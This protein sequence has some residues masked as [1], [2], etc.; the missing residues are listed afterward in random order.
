MNK[1]SILFCMLS[2]MV[3]ASAGCGKSA[4]TEKSAAPKATDKPVELIFTGLPITEEE[5]Q[6]QFGQ[7]IH[8][9]YPHITAK[10]IQPS[11]GT[12][13]K[14]L[15][16][17]GTIPDVYMTATVNLPIF[18]GFKLGYDLNEYIKKNSFDLT[19]FEPNSLQVMKD[20]TAEQMIF[21]LPYQ[22][23]GYVLY[24]NKDVFDKFGVAYPKDGMTWDDTYELAKKL[25]RVEGG[26]TY[27]GFTANWSNIF[28]TNNQLGLAG[29]DSKTDKAAINTDDWKMVFNNVKRF[30]DIPGNERTKDNVPNGNQ[31]SDFLT[32]TVAM[33]ATGIGLMTQAADKGNIHFDYV[34][35]PTYKEA[36]GVGTKTG[37]RYLLPTN[38]SKYKDE[39]FRAISYLTTDEY[40]MRA[41]KEG[42]ATA[43]VNKDIQKAYMQNHPKLKDKNNFAYFYNKVASTPQT[44]PSLVEINT[45]NIAAAELTKVLIGESD[46]PT[47][48]RTAEE[49]INQAVAA[50]KNQ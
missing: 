23:G 30:F 3:T 42:R 17:A 29:L 2:L 1:R 41:S 38:T 37:G 10:Y 46:V 19:R 27:R 9:K 16:N 34:A 18:L 21:G 13:L 33:T 40:Q 32:G 35:L 26:T 31:E 49:K 4:E 44:N 12:E 45:Y 39:V 7:P 50:K 11:K 20:M 15:V 24:Y 8:E 36:P 14:D 6:A 28:L 5:F 25:T 48:L 47:A 43:L 22:S